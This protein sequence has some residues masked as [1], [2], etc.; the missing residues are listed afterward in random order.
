MQSQQ[1][2]SQLQGSQLG[3][4]QQIGAVAEEEEQ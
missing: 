2:G 1:Q 4:Q 3:S